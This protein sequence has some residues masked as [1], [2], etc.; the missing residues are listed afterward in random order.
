[1]YLNFDKVDFALFWEKEFQ[2][3]D[4]LRGGHHAAG[5]LT[6]IRKFD[7]FQKFNYFVGHGLS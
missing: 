3:R 6:L 7:K 5:I 4:V 2:C 1:M